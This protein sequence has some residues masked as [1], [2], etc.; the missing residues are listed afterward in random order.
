MS[1]GAIL[2]G[3]IQIGGE[4]LSNVQARK[5]QHR[6][7]KFQEYMSSTAHQREVKD[8]RAAGLNPILSASG[9]R[10]ASTPGGATFTPQNVVKNAVSSAIQ[11]KRARAELK[12]LDQENKLKKMQ[13]EESLSRIQLQQTQK[14]QTRAQEQQ[15]LAL[16][17]QLKTQLPGALVEK[18]I[19]MSTYG[20]YLRWLG[21]ANPFGATAR[22]LFRGK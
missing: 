7:M 3:A 20:Q 14:H 18:E 5:S 12:I 17:K 9:G 10:G 6:Q 16:T 21:R 1:F 8:L 15:I 13:T 19:D 11:V 4:I 2:G 22:Q